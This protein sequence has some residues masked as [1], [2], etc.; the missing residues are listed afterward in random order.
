M[1]GFVC[2]SVR[3]CER[4]SVLCVS[5]CEHVCVCVCE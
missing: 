4:V 5:M 1:C 3:V 2:K